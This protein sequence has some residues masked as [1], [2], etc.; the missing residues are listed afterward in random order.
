MEIN[1]TLSII[2]P[3]AMKSKY[4]GKI[5]D[6]LEN[7]GFN[8]IAQKKMR[9]TKKQ[10]ETF[11]AIHKDRPFFNELVEFMISGDI[12][13]QV[14]EADNA[15]SYYREIMGN[16]DPANADEGTIRKLYGNNIQCNAVHGSDSQEN[17]YIEINFFF[18]KLELI[19]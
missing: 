3:D 1:K 18:S 16:T 13:V 17:A 12:S 14:L 19:T 2:K 15:V 7:K 4:Q 10:A 5:L 11:Y 6:Y 9:L 8:I